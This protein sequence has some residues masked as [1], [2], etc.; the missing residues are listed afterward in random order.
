[1]ISKKIVLIGDFSTGKT[2]LIRRYIDNS[3]SDKY[4]STIGVKVSVK[5]VETSKQITLR[6]LIWDI[7]GG[8]VQSPINEKYLHGTHGAI[9]VADISRDE[10]ITN[11]ASY[12]TKLHERCDDPAIVIAINKMDLYDELTAYNKLEAA[13]K[14]YGSNVRKLFLTSAKTGYNVE[15]L[16][17]TLADALV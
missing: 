16:F 15:K 13:E 3:F 10:S 2:S 4:L 6:A 14:L 9:I 8:T 1:M 12:I 11:I 5:L 17:H 7:E